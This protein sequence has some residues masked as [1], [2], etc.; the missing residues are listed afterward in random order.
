MSEALAAPFTR[1]RRLGRGPWGGHSVYLYERGWRNSAGR[2]TPA[3][4]F[5]G[6]R[7]TGWG[8]R[9]LARAAAAARGWPA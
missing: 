7:R 3:G 2:L 8:A 6:V 1:V 9:R 4:E 5:L